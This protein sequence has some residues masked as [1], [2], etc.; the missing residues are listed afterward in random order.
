MNVRNAGYSSGISQLICFKNKGVGESVQLMVEF[1]SSSSMNHAGCSTMTL[2]AAGDTL[3]IYVG[4]G[5]INFDGNDNWSVTHI[6]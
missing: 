3:G 5:Q 2:M 4:A 6:G 1:G